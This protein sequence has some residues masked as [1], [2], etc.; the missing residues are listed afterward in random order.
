VFNLTFAVSDSLQV[1]INDDFFKNNSPMATESY[2][3]TL[4]SFSVAAGNIT[5]NRELR[6]YGLLCIRNILD[7]LESIFYDQHMDRVHSV[8]VVHDGSFLLQ[9]L[10]SNPKSISDSVLFLDVA[11]V[12]DEEHKGGKKSKAKAMSEESKDSWSD[13][14][15]A[16]SSESSPLRLRASSTAHGDFNLPRRWKSLQG[17]RG[18]EPGGG[19]DNEVEEEEDE[20]GAGFQGEVSDESEDEESRGF[21]LASLIAVAFFG[22][23]LVNSFMSGKAV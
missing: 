6:D 4:P 13:I 7:C 10:N 2:Y 21:V 12:L 9:L 17:D 18:A 11:E 14:D 22:V 23:A 3:G 15:A 1:S 5:A 19:Y 20:E 8:V 16:D